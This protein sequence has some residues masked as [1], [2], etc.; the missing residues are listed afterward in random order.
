MNRSRPANVSARGRSYR[1]VGPAELKAAVRPGGGGCRIGSAA[2]FGGWTAERSAA[3][4]AEPFTF[5]VGTDGVLRPAP[6]RSEHMACAGGG[7][8]LS[9]DEISF[10]READ[11]WAVSE[12]SNQS[13]GYCPDVS[14]WPEVARAL[15]D[16]GLAS[17]TSCA[18]TTSSASSAA[19]SCLRRGTWMPPC[20]SRASPSLVDG[21]D[22]DGRPVADRELVVVRGDGAVSLEAVDPVLKIGSSGAEGA[23][24]AGVMRVP[25]TPSRC[26]ADAGTGANRTVL[27]RA[28]RVST[29][30]S[31]T[32]RRRHPTAGR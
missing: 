25:L 9:A 26:R 12:V 24:A 15:D 31:F 3:E 2:D 27:T 7:M 5:V 29:A 8:V 4:L 6:R 30:V 16:V 20:D 22:E 11:R 23:D 19:A 17:T 18:R 32:G 21:S 14:S 13:T 10:T 28:A 1:Y